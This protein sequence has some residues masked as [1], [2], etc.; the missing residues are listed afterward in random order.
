[1][2]LMKVVNL[3]IICLIMVSLLIACVPE[4]EPANAGKSQLTESAITETNQNKVN[5]RMG[6]VEWVNKQTG[7]SQELKN[8]M[9]RFDL[10][11]SPTT[12]TYI[13]EIEMNSVIECM[14]VKG[15]VSSVSST[16]STQQQLV[17]SPFCGIWKYLVSA[18]GEKRSDY[19]FYDCSVH[20]V[21][22]PQLDGSY[23]TN[24]N[25]IFW[26]DADDNYHEWLGDYKLSTKPFVIHAQPLFEGETNAYTVKTK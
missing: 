19:Q 4:P 15:K 13:C 14:T 24:G 17:P 11:N 5:K 20:V 3:S 2:K 1:M 12:V 7:Y 26:F 18:T 22:S 6:I 10:F 8:L 23:G 16:L 21:D 25:A 9:K